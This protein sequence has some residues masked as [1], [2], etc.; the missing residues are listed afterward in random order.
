MYLSLL[1]SPFLIF[2]TYLR[3]YSSFYFD[4]IERS[5]AFWESL[6]SLSGENYDI[7]L[8]IFSF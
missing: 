7:F 3:F 8:L 1:M 2:S 6:E 5:K 4:Y